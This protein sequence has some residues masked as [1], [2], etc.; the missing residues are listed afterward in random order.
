MAFQASL[1]PYLKH[2]G[3][4]SIFGPTYLKH[5]VFTAFLGQ[6]T[7][8]TL[9]FTAFWLFKHLGVSI[10]FGPKHFGV[11]T[12]VLSNLAPNLKHFGHV[13]NHHNNHF[14]SVMSHE[15]CE[16]F[17]H[18][19]K[20]FRSAEVGLLAIVKWFTQWETFDCRLQVKVCLDLDVGKQWN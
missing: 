10:I 8:S 18:N 16:W 5:F 11:N 4:S 12:G 14:L 15:F 2:F 20:L 3:V 7:K 1:G 6:L 9:M 19:Q 17:D 13:E